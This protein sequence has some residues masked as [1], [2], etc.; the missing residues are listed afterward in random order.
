MLGL[1][2][3]IVHQVSRVINTGQILPNVNNLFT[4]PRQPSRLTDTIEVVFNLD[5][6]NTTPVLV[7]L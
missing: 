4:I 2:M 7:I 3:C 5:N 6:L 1:F